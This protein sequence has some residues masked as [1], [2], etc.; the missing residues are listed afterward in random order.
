MTA[1][2]ATTNGGER[3][4]CIRH[5]MRDGRVVSKEEHIDP[6]GDHENWVD[7]DIKT[8]YHE[9]FDDAVKEYNNNQKR[10]DRKIKDYFQSVKKDKKKNFAYEMII[11]VYQKECEIPTETKK[12]ILK[13][14]YKWFDKEFGEHI[15]ICGAY[16]HND[17]CG[18]DPH[19][20]LDYIPV[21]DN[22]K[23][24]MKKQ[25]S[26]GQALT[27]L[28][29][30]TEGRAL[31]NQM[32][33]ERY[34]NDKLEALCKERGIFVEHPMREYAELNGMH[35]RH[36]STHQY[37]KDELEKAIKQKESAIKEY[38]MVW[39]D[40]Q[41]KYEEKGHIEKEIENKNKEYDTL[42]EKMIENTRKYQNQNKIIE[43]LDL[44]ITEKKNVT[45]TLDNEYVIL[46]S[47]YNNLNNNLNIILERKENEKEKIEQPKMMSAEDI[48]ARMQ[49]DF[50][51]DEIDKMYNKI[52][53]MYDKRKLSFAKNKFIDEWN[54]SIKHL[55]IKNIKIRLSNELHR[56]DIKPNIQVKKPTLHL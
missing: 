6:K 12:E 14:Y 18:N 49:K 8:M 27:Q 55:P 30:I 37:I 42:N 13:E 51:T 7:R 35:I 20:H 16:Y 33:F 21:A 3:F 31:T 38:K 23:M 26:L 25:N 53:D 52:I 22:C 29:F 54:K 36:K 17:E 10:N 48:K 40:T 11:G 50:D 4:V 15:K 34:C 5:N 39:E 47:K 41:K 24:G 2:I 43:G 46:K 56:F 1:T 28:G 19:L 9:L 45:M 44:E 32:K